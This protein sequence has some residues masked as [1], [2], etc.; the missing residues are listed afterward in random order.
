M[1]HKNSQKDFSG[2]LLA[3][4]RYSGTYHYNS[5]GYPKGYPY[6]PSLDTS[7]RRGLVYSVP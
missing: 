1:S 3:D 2:A 4:L 5:Q 7:R 6:K